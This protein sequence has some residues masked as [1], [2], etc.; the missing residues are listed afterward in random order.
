MTPYNF[1]ERNLRW[2]NFNIKLQ[3]SVINIFFFSHSTD[4]NQDI[5]PTFSLFEALFKKKKF[6]GLV[7][8]A[9]GNQIVKNYYFL[10]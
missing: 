5:L 2:G 9:R 7:H 4:I 6:V 10:I 1:E 8:P 3:Q